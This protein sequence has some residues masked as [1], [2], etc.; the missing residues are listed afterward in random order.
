MQKIDIGT[1]NHAELLLENIKK[2]AKR[3]F[4]NARGSHDWDH[5]LRVAK[6]CERIGTAEGV[7]MDVLRVAAYLHDIGRC[8]Q[9]DS[10]GVVCHAE[11]GAKMAMPIAKA[12][13]LTKKQK[14]NI[15]HCIRSHRFRGNHAPKTKEAKVLFDADKLDAIGAV[16]VARAYLFAG[17]VGARL[18]NSGINV[19][20]AKPYS[21]DDTGFRE[22]KVKLCKI[23]DRIITKEGGKLANER[24]DFMEQ[25]FKRFIKEYEGER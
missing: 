7:D 14:E 5:T 3:M 15:I 17:E 23:R 24:H 1:K 13:P 11:I 2:L 6:L 4:D 22:F 16:G 20:E 8:Y 18:H 21:K 9:D 19:E 10:N 12:L 25:F